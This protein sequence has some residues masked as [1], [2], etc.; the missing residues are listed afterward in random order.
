M[1]LFSFLTRDGFTAQQSLLGL[2]RFVQVNRVLFIRCAEAPK[3]GASLRGFFLAAGARVS[4]SQGKIQVRS[5]AV[6]SFRNFQLRNGAWEIPR[7]Q[8]QK[9]EQ[10]VAKRILGREFDN[11]FRVFDAISRVQAVTSR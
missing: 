9:T 6:S 8:I 4:V 1:A 11:L 5:L 7:V 10:V 3:C 2:F